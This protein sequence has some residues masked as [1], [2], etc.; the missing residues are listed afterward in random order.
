MIDL[1]TLPQGYASALKQALGLGGL[2][3]R[4]ALRLNK[5]PRKP[6]R[7]K[8]MI[9]GGRELHPTKGFYGDKKHGNRSN[10]T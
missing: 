1:G 9:V 10:R 4:D 7:I 3:T 5:S 8:R 6:K 2:L